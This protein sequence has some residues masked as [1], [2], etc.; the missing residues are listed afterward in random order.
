MTTFT[1]EA[2]FEQALINELQNTVCKPFPCQAT[3]Q[4]WAENRRM[5]VIYKQALAEQ[6]LVNI[7][8]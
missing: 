6:D 1:S 7:W 4:S 5:T 2:Q 8:L 3:C